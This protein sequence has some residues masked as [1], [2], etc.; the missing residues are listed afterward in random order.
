MKAARLTRGALDHYFEDKEVIFRV[1]VTDE[2][3][4]VADEINTTAKS[5]QTLAIDA[6]LTSL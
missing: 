2:Y 4:T 3:M 1:V 5:A 6:L